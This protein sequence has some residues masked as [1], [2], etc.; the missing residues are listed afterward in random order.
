MDFIRKPTTSSS[1]SSG[2]H[3]KVGASTN[4]PVFNNITESDGTSIPFSSP[5]LS[6][7]VA[8]IIGSTIAGAMLMKENESI[9]EELKTNRI[10][11]EGIIDKLEKTLHFQSQQ[12]QVM[13]KE[14]E[15]HNNFVSEHSDNS[16]KI[17]NALRRQLDISRS[18]NQLV[19]D[20]SEAQTQDLNQKLSDLTALVNVLKLN[21]ADETAALNKKVLY[22]VDCLRVAKEDNRTM[23]ECYEDH[24]SRLSAELDLKI[25]ESSLK[26]QEYLDRIEELTAQCKEQRLR[27]QVH[28]S[29]MTSTFSDD[30]AVSVGYIE[31]LVGVKSNRDSVL[32]RTLQQHVERMSEA[33]EARSNE[34]NEERQLWL[35]YEELFV[36]DVNLQ[37]MRCEDMTMRAATIV[38]RCQQE[39]GEFAQQVHDINALRKQQ[40]SDL[41][42]ARAEISTL[43]EV[44]ALDS[45]SDE[46]I[47]EYQKE[48][49]RLQQEY[50]IKYVQMNEEVVY[51]Q[52]DLDASLH[53][54]D[55]LEMAL[56]DNHHTA[57]VNQVTEL[58]QENIRL[59]AAMK[60]RDGVVQ[61]LQE[62][63]AELEKLSHGRAATYQAQVLQLQQELTA[64]L[65]TRRSSKSH[66]GSIIVPSTE[67]GAIRTPNFNI[68]SL[69][70]SSKQCELDADHT[71]R[72]GDLRRHSFVFIGDNNVHT[73]DNGQ[74]DNS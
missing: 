5:L 47:T 65:T 28:A 36:Q 54:L 42:A 12:L 18:E 74:E 6:M 49:H 71:V 52:R 4:I 22:L 1:S 40:T 39:I 70:N 30:E 55:Q 26:N 38:K 3:S 66:R 46:K 29:T 41:L 10:E 7:T 56:E 24:L 21:H 13:K 31:E 72:G 73:I 62:E 25:V 53:K 23:I 67:E 8:E 48:I 68:T 15:A 51:L 27:Q 63:L 59:Q 50:T 69:S 19:R 34:F 20:Q 17:V 64:S 11:F 33:L 43:N 37:M 35:S 14:A 60:D 45:F 9:R 32:L 57:I 58:Q 2:S 44:A 61:Q 16:A